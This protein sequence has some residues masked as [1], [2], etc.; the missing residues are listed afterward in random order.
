MS[1]KEKAFV[2]L[3]PG[4]AASE[5]DT[6]CLP[7]QQQLVRTISELFPGLHI[8]ILSFQYPYCEKSYNWFR[9][10][11]ISFNGRNKGGL[12]RLLL[13]RKIRTALNNIQAEKQIIGLL[14]FW[15]NECAAV[16]KVFGEKNNIPHYC[17]LLGQDAR[18]ENRYPK[19]LRVQASELIALSDFLQ[20]EFEKNH[21]IRPLP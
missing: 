1:N 5:G 12:P 17:W 19:R 2:I 11:V 6:V 18:Q 16:G 20:E 21:G 15:L 3:T 8:F 14:S 9:A 7:M 4:F 10:R 13:R